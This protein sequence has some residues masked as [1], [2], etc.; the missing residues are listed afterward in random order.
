M[1]LISPFWGEAWGESGYGWLPYAYV[2]AGLAIDFWT[3]VWPEWLA[4]GE[5]QRPG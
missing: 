1:R 5:F 4:S 2:T 3:L